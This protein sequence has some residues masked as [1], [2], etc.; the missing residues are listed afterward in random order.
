MNS[1]IL[2]NIL[3]LVAFIIPALPSSIILRLIILFSY[4]LLHNYKVHIMYSQLKKKYIM[5]EEKKE[6][7][8]LKQ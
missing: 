1:K 4:L 3:E 6:T 7:I 5:E 2:F 8:I